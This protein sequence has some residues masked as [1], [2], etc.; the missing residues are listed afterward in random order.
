M[1]GNLDNFILAELRLPN[2]EMESLL[3]CPDCKD[4]YT[5]DLKILSKPIKENEETSLERN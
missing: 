4:P 1:E 5:V 2:P 3:K